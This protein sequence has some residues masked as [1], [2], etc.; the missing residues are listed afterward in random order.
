MNKELDVLFD[1]L[2]HKRPYAGMGDEG[3][4]EKYL[5]VIPKMQKD[6]FGNRIL[7]VGKHP[8]VM[9]SSHTDTVHRSEGT[10]HN[11]LDETRQ[12]V[13]NTDGDCLGA[14]DGAGMWIMLQL[15]KAGKRGLYVFHRGE[16]CGG[17][18]SDYIA[19]RTP[20]LLDGI[21]YCIAFD[22]KDYTN[23]ITH[24]FSG[25]GCS[26]VFASALA[27]AIGMGYKPDPTGIFTDS[28]NYTHIIP[29]CTNISVGYFAEHTAAELLDYGF[30]Q[31]LTKKLKS[32]VFETLPVER[33][34]E[35][36]WVD[37]YAYNYGRGAHGWPTGADY[38]EFDEA[39]G[40]LNDDS[41]PWDDYDPFEDA[42]T[43]IDPDISGAGDSF[44]D[45]KGDKEFDAMYTYI[46]NHPL[47]VT[48][49]LL[50]NGYTPELLKE[51]KRYY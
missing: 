16:E 26:D 5:D 13:F 15:I 22:R 9:F 48:D 44:F 12:E 3:I 27:G 49:L 47:D 7:A 25:R 21:K 51:K 38:K 45:A 8:T 23:I 40:R 1:I 35:D 41:P 39:N 32:V 36:A 19:N 14:D 10:N 20:E 30:L 18:G 42:A 37:P 33:D 11:F 29:E 17:L 24:Q 28:D 2:S 43:V 31:R 6:G 4:I 34:P 50:D 46:C